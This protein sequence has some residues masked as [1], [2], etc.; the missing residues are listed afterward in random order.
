MVLDNRRTMK[1]TIGVIGIVLMLIGGALVFTGMSG[2]AIAA[3]KLD[4]SYSRFNADVTRVNGC[5]WIVF[6]GNDV[7]GRSQGSSIH[8]EHSPTCSNYKNHTDRK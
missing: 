3:D 7:N 5:T 2:S 1:N 4:L 6:T 8:A